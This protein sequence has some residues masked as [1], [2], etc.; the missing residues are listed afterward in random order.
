M[1]SIADIAAAVELSTGTVSQILSRRDT[2]YSERT[3]LRVQDAAK[4]LG[5]RPNAMAKA[6]ECGRSNAV[7]IM[8]ADL[9]GSLANDI[10]TSALPVLEAAGYHALIG[11]NLWSPEREEQELETFLERR[12][13]GILALPLDGQQAHYQTIQQ[14]GVPLV[15]MCD[16]LPG[17]PADVV[18][19]DG[20]AAGVTLTEHLLAQGHR[21][22]ALVSND[23]QSEQLHA[24]QAGYRAALK[25]AG[26]TPDPTLE[27]FVDGA[28]PESL[29]T[30]TLGLTRHPRPPT[31]I[32][33]PVEA[34][35]WQAM[36]L[37][38]DVPEARRPVVAAVGGLPMSSHRLISL[39]TVNEP[40]A[41][42]GR[43][44]AE[45]LLARM[46]DRQRAPR[47][48]LL[49]GDLAVRASTAPKKTMALR[50]GG[51]AA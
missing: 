34:V 51:V 47:Q 50:K 29:K 2:R 4:R 40:L 42:I 45:R 12:L 32:V 28:D 8:F 30:L 1:V 20:H 36:E 10:L 19:L 27:R 39:T 44:A 9:N 43:L 22:I 13:E 14:A 18:A 35:A 49:R 6:L 31:A 26:I 17:I 37:L 48:Q 5:Y 38:C 11:V 3:R 46:A 21:R 24:R 15:F 23:N 16:W 25:A 33:F 7:G 41:K